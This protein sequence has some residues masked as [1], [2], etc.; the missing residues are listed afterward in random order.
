MLVS[1]RPNIITNRYQTNNKS[2]KTSFKA[3]DPELL[4]KV[5]KHDPA[6][7]LDGALNSFQLTFKNNPLK[8]QDLWDTMEK[9]KDTPG[10]LCG[11]NEIKDWPEWM[12]TFVK[13]YLPKAIH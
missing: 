8:M 2:Q 11:K 9:A 1:F 13:P 7:A 6:E 4:G 12:E 5:L 10:F 3:V